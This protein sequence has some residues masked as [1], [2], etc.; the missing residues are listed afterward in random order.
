MNTK[1]SAASEACSILSNATVASLGTLTEAGAP[2]LSLV[3]V[4]P[5][6]EL[7]LAMLLSGLAAHTRNLHRDSRCSLLLTKPQQ[8][9]SNPLT[10]PRLTLTGSATRLERTDDSSERDAFLAVHPDASM[11][12]D[13]GD[14]AVWR[15]EFSNA[16]FVAGF[17]RIVSLKPADFKAAD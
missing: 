2:F 12:A 1:P 3:T 11:Y 14:F 17:G 15:F 13:F 6:G 4:A 10:E 7:H 8:P 9:N 5:V 16:H